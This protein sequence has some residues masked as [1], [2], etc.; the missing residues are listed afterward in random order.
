MYK[1]SIK[2][3][4]PVGVNKGLPF[5]V[6]YKYC[7]EF[8][9]WF[10]KTDIFSYYFDDIFEFNT[11]PEPTPYYT[12][13][14]IAAFIE[15]LNKKEP[16]KSLE[17]YYQFPRVDLAV[18]L[19]K[20]FNVAPRKYSEQIIENIV[21]IESTRIEF[22]RLLLELH[23]LDPANNPKPEVIEKTDLSKIKF[24]FTEE[25]LKRNEEKKTNYFKK[26]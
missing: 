14:K 2:A 11:L 10:I 15:S 24:S 5:S 22:N 25:V 7:P 4:C 8:I 12:D 21:K 6:I 16:A 26:R 19:L 13:D 18:N 23:E 9:E 3:P 20:E 17:K 1:L